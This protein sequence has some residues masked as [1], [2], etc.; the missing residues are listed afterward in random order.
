[1]YLR[2]EH[3]LLGANKPEQERAQ[4]KLAECL[5]RPVRPVPPLSPRPPGPTA[6]PSTTRASRLTHPACLTPTQGSTYQKALLKLASRFVDNKLQLTQV[7]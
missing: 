1:M 7:K 2:K 5:S 6:S 4:S 3:A